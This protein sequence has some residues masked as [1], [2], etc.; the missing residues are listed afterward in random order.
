MVGPGRKC[1]P[2]GCNLERRVLLSLATGDTTSPSAM[3]IRP[4]ISWCRPKQEWVVPPAV[5][6][7]TRAAV[8]TG[9]SRPKPACRIS[10]KRTLKERRGRHHLA[11]IQ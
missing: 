5:S 10:Q 4:R 8:A 3:K 1:K 11:C 9:S 6:G 2:A 7:H